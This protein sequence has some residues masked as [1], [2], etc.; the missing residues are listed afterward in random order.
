MKKSMKG[1][2]IPLVQIAF[3]LS[4]GLCS[5]ACG[6]VDG[7]RDQA[8]SSDKDN[9]TIQVDS[10]GFLVN[11]QYKLLRGGSVQWFRMPE[12]V[13]A[14]RLERFKAAGFNTI[15]MYVPW[16][17]IEPEEGRFNFEKPDIRHFLELAKRQGLYVYL[18]PG[19]YITNEMDGGGVPGWVFTRTTKKSIA[20]DGKMNL[21]THD[22]DYLQAVER[23]FHA[24][25]E[26]IRPYLITRGGPIILY[27]VENEYEW[28]EMF[29]RLDRL[30]WYEGGF[31]RNP[32]QRY[33]NL[34]YFTAL[35][36]MVRKDGVD[37]PL[38]TCPGSGQVAGMGDVEGIIPMP[39]LYKSEKTEAA[40]YNIIATMHDPKK[41]GGKY[42][43]FPS[44]ISETD[45]TATRMKRLLTGGL[46]AFFAF[47]A[48]GM[49][50]P[51]YQNSVTLGARPDG[52][53]VFD[54]STANLVNGFL[55]PGV[56][57]LHNVLD[58]YGPISASGV[59]REKFH[60]FRRTNLLF[61]ALE[62]RVGRVLH[63]C[64]S[65]RKLEGG[66]PRLEI[67]GSEIGATEDNQKVHSWLDLGDGTYLLSLVNESS[68]AQILEPGSIRVDDLVF[69]RHNRLRVPLEV[70]P[71]HPHKTVV[72]P[73]HSGGEKV[74]LETE[75]AMLLVTGLPLTR[76]VRLRYAT[77]ELLTQR[78]FNGTSLVVLYG[79]EG[80]RG[81]LM[82]EGQGGPL[83]I[84]SK[85]DS[86]TVHEQQDNRLVFSIAYLPNQLVRLQS[87]QG[88]SILVLATTRELAGRAWFFDAKDQQVAIIGLD[89]VRADPSPGDGGLALR[90]ENA[91]PAARVLTL[92]KNPIQLDGFS[93]VGAFDGQT[94]ASLWE[95][96]DSEALPSLPGVLA[97]G[98]VKSDQEESLPGY[99]AP[100]TAVRWQGAPRPLEALGVL[101]GHAWY[102]T[103]FDAGSD[104]ASRDWNLWIEHASDIV[105]IYANGTYLTTVSPLGTEIDN[106]SRN[107]NYVFP[108]LKPYLRPG[109]N[110]LAFRV[111]IW[112]HGSFMFPR[113]TFAGIT[114]SVPSLGFDSVKGLWGKAQIGEV[115]LW[116]WTLVPRLGGERA[117]FPAVDFDD[118]DWTAAALPIQ[119]KPGEVLWYRTAL[120]RS[121]LPDPA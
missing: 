79:T 108:D 83:Q 98:R 89:Y 29:S 9:R 33:D 74:N 91:S 82:L 84:V 16:N 51:G 105:G 90:F 56:G 75:Y 39:N 111:E 30:A 61:D 73:A 13:W 26:V 70:Y 76:N 92:S 55:A 12:Q 112:G 42:V 104:V 34:R 121:D 25:N 106:K 36:D 41:F 57:Y 99:S 71:G 18:R 14:D 5:G 58:Y 46:D 115:A 66:D 113:G 52:V 11:G 109:K 44:G 95:R 69:P 96:G 107:S 32:L 116:D 40:A 77:G 19:P 24:L 102:R 64:R 50:T 20:A 63:P 6:G 53:N 86:V 27:A 103:E 45:R 78:A 28:F 22:P 62:E 43:N 120:R 15:D 21:R 97:R 80:D 94:G 59:L 93:P 35:R 88:E 101:T 54:F 37:V 119:T 38:T 17:L 4:L 47:N 1:S 2:L 65:G 68:K 72:Y 23:Y 7:A 87:A 67:A 118:Q 81:E 117:G 10:R 48:V 60:N 31:E 114:L 85:S 100:A 49:N 3:L 8:S 110:L